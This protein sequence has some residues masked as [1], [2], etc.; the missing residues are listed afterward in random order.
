MTCVHSLFHCSV[1]LL[2]CD[3]DPQHLEKLAYLARRMQA[4]DQERQ[5]LLAALSEFDAVI[6]SA[7]EAETEAEN[8]TKAAPRVVAVPSSSKAPPIPTVLESADAALIY[9]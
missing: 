3:A 9:E 1:D 4:I 2:A 5:G 8:A 7:T 6:S